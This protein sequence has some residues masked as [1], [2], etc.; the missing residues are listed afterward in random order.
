MVKP[1]AEDIDFTTVGGNDA[2]W[3]R[4]PHPLAY[5]DA[6]GTAHIQ[7]SR[8]AGPTLGWTAR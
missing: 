4:A 3:L 6:A 1:Y 5:T 8:I 2:F 7:P